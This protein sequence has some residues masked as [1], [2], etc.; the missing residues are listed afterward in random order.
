[1]FFFDQANN[2]ENRISYI[3]K[4]LSD[5]IIK[6]NQ[7]KSLEN[8]FLDKYGLNLVI[9]CEVEFYFKNND[10]KIILSDL[11]ILAENINLKKE[12][13]HLQYEFDVSPQSTSQNLIEIV[14]NKILE[15][16]KF[17]TNY[18]MKTDF[19][20]KPYDDD[21]GNSLH[22]HINFLNQNNKNLFDD[23]KQLAKVASYLCSCMLKYFIFSAPT[24]NCYKRFVP[25]FM[26]PV[27][28]SWGGNNRTTAIRI[29][30]GVKRLEYRLASP[31]CDLNII[32][33]LLLKQILS[34][35]E[36]DGDY[37]N[38]YPMIFGNADDLQ[39]DLT[40]FPKS[41]NESLELF[42]KAR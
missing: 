5:Y 11:D 3:S 27:N 9:G 17:A 13:G 40:P 15:I 8:I 32:I 28:V 37:L 2:L 12:K 42:L 23:K 14:Q 16:K 20:A 41:L 22:I 25:G 24:E 38:K 19:S 31:V 1:M 10:S 34:S 26:A 39:Y 21:Y 29:P 6:S 33:Y 18:G 7:L 35:M 30:P 4:I 36:A